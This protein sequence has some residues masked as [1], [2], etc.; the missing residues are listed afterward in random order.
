MCIVHYGITLA[1][2][3]ICAWCEI[4]C[5]LAHAHL[6][7]N[8]FYGIAVSMVCMSKPLA[9]LSPVAGG[10]LSVLRTGCQ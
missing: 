10:A 4:L 3:I 5:H 9:F 2:N 1:D 7:L 8:S 6:S